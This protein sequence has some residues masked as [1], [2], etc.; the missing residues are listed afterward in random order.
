MEGNTSQH[1]SQPR[2]EGLGRVRIPLSVFLPC[3]QFKDV[4]LISVPSLSTLETFTCHLDLLNIKCIIFV[5]MFWPLHMT[6]KLL[7]FSL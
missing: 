1:P 2:E 7:K 3:V 6:Q 4:N 5:Q